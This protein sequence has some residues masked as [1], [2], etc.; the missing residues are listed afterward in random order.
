MDEDEKKRK[1]QLEPEH[2]W[3]QAGFISCL[4]INHARLIVVCGNI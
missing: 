4:I 3:N 2:L 1:L